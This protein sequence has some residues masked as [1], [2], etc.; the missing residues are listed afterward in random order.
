MIKYMKPL[1]MFQETLKRTIDMPQS[2]FIGFNVTDKNVSL[3]VSDYCYLR[4]RALCVLPRD[5]TLLDNLVSKVQD[6]GF[7]LE[8]II[9]AG[10]YHDSPPMNIH[11]LIH[12]LC[13]KGKF[14]S[15]KYACYTD[16]VTSPDA[17]YAKSQYLKLGW[18]D[19]I[20]ISLVVHML[21]ANVD[22][23][24]TLVERHKK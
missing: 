8:G 7:D 10:K 5:Q 17:K 6:C 15:L 24:N 13:K 20:D 19:S 1:K 21:Q 16:N 9:V 4:A 14:Q 3:A 2:V 11:N 22:V 23:F 18:K 12:D